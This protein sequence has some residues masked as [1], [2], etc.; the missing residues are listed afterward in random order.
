MEIKHTNTNPQQLPLESLSRHIGRVGGLDIKPANRLNSVSEYYF[1]KKLREIAEMNAQGKNV[2]SLGIGSPDLPPS[3]ETI[4]ALCTEAHKPGQGRT[5][6]LTRT[7]AGAVRRDLPDSRQ[8]RQPRGRHLHPGAW[9]S[10]EPFAAG[11]RPV[12]HAQIK[13][14]VEPLSRCPD[15]PDT[16]RTGEAHAQALAASPARRC[17]C[18]CPSVPTRCNGYWP[19]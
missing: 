11:N 6:A 9:K 16:A 3:E 7:D 1:S 4:E 17:W 8:G 12:P 15:K 10:L 2:L 18:N 19:R 14:T 5:G 13:S